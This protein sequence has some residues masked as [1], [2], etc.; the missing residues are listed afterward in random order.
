[1]ISVVNRQHYGRRIL[2][3]RPRKRQ[4]TKQT[5]ARRLRLGVTGYY[6]HK[7]FYNK[8][9]QLMQCHRHPITSISFDGVRSRKQHLVSV[10]LHDGSITISNPGVSSTS[11]PQ[12]FNSRNEDV[13]SSWNGHE[14]SI[15][16]CSWYNDG[17]CLA[18][19]SSD[20]T[21]RLWDVSTRQELASFAFPSGD[22]ILSF[23]TIRPC[24]GNQNLFVSSCRDGSVLLWDCRQL[25][26]HSFSMNGGRSKKSCQKPIQHIVDGHC[27]YTGASSDRSKAKR[28]SSKSLFSSNSSQFQNGVSQAIFGNSDGTQIFSAGASDGL[29]KC[30]DMRRIYHSKLFK[31]RKRKSVGRKMPTPLMVIQEPGVLPLSKEKKEWLGLNSLFI[32]GG[33]VGS[34]VKKY[35]Q[36]SAS[37]AKANRM[38]IG[39]VRQSPTNLNF[40]RKN[41]GISSIDLDPTFSKLLVSYL[42]RPIH[43]YDLAGCVESNVVTKYH[44]YSYCCKSYYAKSIWSSDGEYIL[45]GASNG[46]GYVWKYSSKQRNGCTIPSFVYPVSDEENDDISNV[47]APR[48]GNAMKD[49]SLVATSKI[50]SSHSQEIKFWSMY[51]SEYARR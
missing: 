34:T 14:N 35:D 43:V 39:T 7:L 10:T 48:T 1:M 29:I 46:M 44:G 42:N 4:K 19:A 16:D 21:C 30:W 13:L 37:Q 36:I 23:K 12:Y 31:T 6:P 28:S 15:F 33:S 2:E 8:L 24:L 45:S 11:V 9:P 47:V 20:G 27:V 41:H 3:D 25:A 38:T 51:G 40:L 18:T 26:R 32:D 5:L 22:K 17:K 50:S 49:L